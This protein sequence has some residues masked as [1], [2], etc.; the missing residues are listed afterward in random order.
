MLPA[1]FRPLSARPRSAR[2]TTLSDV[3]K[4]VVPGSRSPRDDDF[5]RSCSHPNCGWVTLFARRFGLF[6]NIARHID[7]DSVMNDVAY[8][9][10]L[11]EQQMCSIIGTRR[12]SWWRSR[13]AAA[14]RKLVRPRDVFGIVIAVHGPPYLRPGSYLRVLPS[15]AGHAWTARIVLRVQRATSRAGL[16][17]APATSGRPRSQRPWRSPAADVTFDWRSIPS[18]AIGLSIAAGIVLAV[19]ELFWLRR[20]GHLTR[21]ALREMAMSLSTLPP[22]I[23]VSLSPEVGGSRSTRRRQLV[24]WRMPMNVATLMLAV[25]AG[26]LCY[27]WEHRCAHRFAWLWAAYHAVHHSR[28]A[29]RWPPRTVSR[30]STS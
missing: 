17:G 20:R 10:V 27:Y 16:V 9:T 13:A 23:V 12:T 6:A 24:A 26:D 29:T 11:D 21:P 15:R 4:G 3:I 7:V 19:E 1:F 2:R 14:G 28:P 30:S 8:K 22:N 25:V 18:A 5:L